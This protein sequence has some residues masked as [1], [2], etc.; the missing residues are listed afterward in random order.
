MKQSYN[1]EMCL[2]YCSIVGSG[3]QS[4]VVMG[5]S[6]NAAYLG[7]ELETLHQVLSRCHI[8]GVKI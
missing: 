4:S 7:Y 6:H 1:E 2:V 3:I 8:R 5:T